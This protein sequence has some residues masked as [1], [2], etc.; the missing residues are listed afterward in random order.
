MAVNL[1]SYAHLHDETLF[2]LK[3][4]Y[5]QRVVTNAPISVYILEDIS[6]YAD[7]L[8]KLVLYI[9]CLVFLMFYVLCVMYYAV[10]KS[11]G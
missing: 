11:A 1:H 9:S 6:I 3:H 8:L 2:L 4:S 10:R 5:T 7:Y